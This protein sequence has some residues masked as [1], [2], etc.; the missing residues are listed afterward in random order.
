MTTQTNEQVVQDN[1]QAAV[2]EQTSVVVDGST[3]NGEQEELTTE[4]KE[5]N[6]L[7]EH[8]DKVWSGMIDAEILK[9]SK[10]EKSLEDLDEGLRKA[11][12]GKMTVKPA[13]Q[14]VGEDEQIVN[15]VKQELIL[16]SMLEA[17]EDETDR[18][19]AK[20]DYNTFVKSGY[21]AAAA[22]AKIKKLHGIKSQAEMTSYGERS[23]VA[24]G[25]TTKEPKPSYNASESKF[26][27]AMGVKI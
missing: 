4:Q 1:E 25:G 27:K 9:V 11:V 3:E 5:A 15:K 6:K 13:T 24:G 16:D 26:L 10:G 7:Q 8:K 23:H 14:K 21:D 12:E 20:R 2:A 18:A 22:Q 17:I 19:E